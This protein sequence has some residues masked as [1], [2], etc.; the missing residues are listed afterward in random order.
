MSALSAGQED[1]RR[2]CEAG[3]YLQAYEAA[4]PC[5][6]LATWSGTPARLLAARLAAE[7]GGHRLGSALL[8][9]AVRAD[10]ASLEARCAAAGA[11]LGRRNPALAWARMREWGEPGEGAPARARAEWLVLQAR[12]AGLFRDFE[13]SGEALR[14]AERLAPAL[15]STAITRAWLL[16]EQDCCV[17]ALE[18]AQESRRAHPSWAPSVLAVAR[19]LLVL[20]RGDE[21]RLTLSDAAAETESG[22]VVGTLAATLAGQRLF[23]ESLGCLDRFEALS[24]LLDRDGRRWLAARRSDALYELGDVEGARQQARLAKHPFHAAIAERL[25][26]PLGDARR[27]LLDVPFVRQ[28]HK[29]C[30]PASLASVASYW[31]RPV[32]HL[33]LAAT[34][35]YDGT[36]RHSAR[37]WAEANGW[38]VRE[39]RLTWASGC[40]LLD[41]GVPFVLA[42]AGPLSGHDQAVVG[43]DARRGSF[44]VR[45]PSQPFLQEVLAGPM[46]DSQRW[47]GPR[48][49]VLLPQAE[50]ERLAGLDLPDARP[51]DCLHRIQISLEAHRPDP[52]R[53]VEQEMEASLPDH[54]LTLWA[55]A[56]VAGYASDEATQAQCLE[57]LLQ[58]F[59]ESP[60]LLFRKISFLHGIA[61]AAEGD[62]LLTEALERHPRDLPL[63]SL[64]AHALSLDRQRHPSA[65][66][67]L[68]SIF[69]AGVSPSTGNDLWG[70]ARTHEAAG[71]PEAAL[72][73][74]R[75]AACLQD[76]NE[77]FAATYFG[78]ARA[79]EKTAEA[80]ALLRR[81]DERLAP[82][83]GHPAAT[84]S[85]ALERCGYEGPAREAMRRA[86]ALHPADGG[87]ALLAA[88]FDAR[89]GRLEAADSLLRAAHGRVRLEAW[90]Q[91]AARV[92]FARVRKARE[93]HSPPPPEQRAPPGPGFWRLQPWIP[94]LLV[95]LFAARTCAREDLDPASSRL[96]F[97]MVLLVALVAGSLAVYLASRKRRASPPAL[98]LERER[99][100]EGGGQPA[101]SGPSRIGR[102]VIGGQL[103][104][105]VGV[106]V[107]RA[108]DERW[109]H[110]VA[111]K[112]LLDRAGAS[113]LRA[114]FLRGAETASRLRHPNI[115]AVYDLGSIEGRPYVA[116]EFLGQGMTLAQAG[117]VPVDL[118]CAVAIALQVLAA[119]GHA[120]ERGVVHL[121]VNPTGLFLEV[122][123]AVK[124]LG[125]FGVGLG[126]PV[127]RGSSAT[128]YLSPEQHQGREADARSD[129]FAVGVI[130]Q[131]LVTGTRALPAGDPTTPGKDVAAGDAWSRLP[132]GPRWIKLRTVVGRALQREP[133]DRYPDAR[134]LSEALL[135]VLETP[136]PSE[137]VV[138]RTRQSFSSIRRM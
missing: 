132:Q 84:L 70:L 135:E 87:L 82:R 134:S 14:R 13:T 110:D 119:L 123:G 85:W 99:P 127:V 83:S 91:A 115:E 106:V 80:L 116:A 9:R 126:G 69:R 46:L 35:C 43:Y 100:R 138:P 125:F 105:G 22:T 53:Q 89:H 32:D 124:V 44:S 137:H 94:L 92:L 95:Q 34:I 15:P 102:Y 113:D 122:H 6:P 103:G 109:G 67:V 50:H 68:R 3:R 40:A 39:F 121:G 58:R 61:P 130:L 107:Y 5:G 4:G 114:R 20:G 101:A 51:Y 128:A 33:S 36:P 59:P 10:P 47:S 90:L 88:D 108:R 72:E 27:V 112:V 66:R 49:F 120:H 74:L 78:A 65:L 1:V 7:L 21:A 93:A 117:G 73:L 54:A 45:E 29:T 25:A 76:M 56:L 18:V 79:R 55:A 31:S 30:T 38:L 16:E 75:F 60:E 98:D 37:E 129:L 28:H 57:G 111:V 19:L 96:V 12:I 62:R 71:R 8:L 77:A 17:E 64:R 24:P 86:V 2:L 11:L 136:E 41:R 52:A 42:I 104:G 26:R 48:A 97:T 63:L 118:H 133:A 131:E 23:A 81:R